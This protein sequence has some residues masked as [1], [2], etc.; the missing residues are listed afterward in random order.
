MAGFRAHRN[1]V[2]AGLATAAL[3]LIP[4]AMASAP[5]GGGMG[6]GG[7]GGDSMSSSGP[8][9]D[10]QA[11][12]Q[13]G[14]EALRSHDFTSA[15][16]HFRDVV[17]VVPNDGTANYALGLA[18]MGNN[19]PRH[20]RGPLERAV[21]ATDAPVNAHLQLG[22]AY[23]QTNDRDHAVQQQAAL[24]DLLTHCD[25]ACGDQRRAQIQAANDAL[26]AALNP[27]TPATAAPP[28]STTTSPSSW[29]FPTQREGH[30]AYAA[31]VGLINTQHYDEA[32][33]MLAQSEAALGQHPDIFTY[34]G[35][36]NRKLHNYDVAIAY[37]QEALHMDRNHLGAT[38]YLGELYLEIGQRA[39]AERQLT[40]L[41]ALCPYGCAEHE[42][43][44]RWIQV[45]SN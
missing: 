29:N 32:L 18:Y 6:G 1:F 22:L 34:M 4:V 38:E 35:F 27:P 12:Y 26:A 41:A 33:D 17:S 24:A 3:A 19:D 39:K 40:R 44:A 43:L 10:P 25:A 16:A 36:A 9:V 31:A 5:G 11:A 7:M 8:R 15:I 37:Y 42:E 30:L 13:A 23:L 20:A 21:H 28:A 14:V 45:A 2:F